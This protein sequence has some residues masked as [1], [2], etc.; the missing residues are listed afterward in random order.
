MAALRKLFYQLHAGYLPEVRNV[1]LTLLYSAAD[2]A[3]LHRH[4]MIKR[5]QKIADAAGTLLHQLLRTHRF[6]PVEPFLADL[7]VI[8]EQLLHGQSLL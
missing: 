5:R 3:V 8:F 1:N 2:P 6:T 4:N 7:P